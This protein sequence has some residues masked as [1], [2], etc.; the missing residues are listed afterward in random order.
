[1]TAPEHTNTYL[2]LMVRYGGLP[3][4]PVADVCRDYFAHLTTENFIRKTLAGE[5]SLPV[6]RMEDSKRTSRGVHLADLA[7]YIERQTAAA[8]KE[9]E[10]L[11]RD[12]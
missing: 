3:V 10:Q 2:L 5:I 7:A 9:C 4:V 6:V 8:R 1:M 11:R 12:Q